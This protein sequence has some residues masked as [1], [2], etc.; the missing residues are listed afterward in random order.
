MAHEEEKNRWQFH[1]PFMFYNHMQM[2]LQN[3]HPTTIKNSL[4][5]F[6]DFPKHILCFTA[7]FVHGQLNTF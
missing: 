6:Y 1:A 5:F 3:R 2:W 7:N 4:P